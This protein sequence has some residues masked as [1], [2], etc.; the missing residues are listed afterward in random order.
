MNYIYMYIYAHTHA[1]ICIYILIHIYPNDV[2]L[3]HSPLYYFSQ[4][5]SVYLE[6]TDSAK[7]ADQG[8]L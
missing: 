4:G 1:Y 2:C 7:L 5:A 6:L 8:A 3:Y